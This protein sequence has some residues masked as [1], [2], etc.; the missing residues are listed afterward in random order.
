MD[1]LKNTYLETF[2]MQANRIKTIPSEFA[3]LISLKSVNF[4]EN[5]LS[6]FPKPFFELKLQSINLSKNYI[7]TLPESIRFLTAI[8]KL[9]LSQNRLSAI[10]HDIIA[11]NLMKTL[12]LHSNMLTMIPESIGE[13]ASLRT[14]DVRENPIFSLPFAMHKL[15][16]LKRLKVDEA[17]TFI[18]PPTDIVKLGTSRCIDYFKMRE[19][20]RHSQH[21]NMSLYAERGSTDFGFH[22]CVEKSQCCR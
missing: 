6:E 20:A 8:T 3:E 9:N 1:I 10:C 16:G 11:L 5:L 15:T 22:T 14:L 18:H 13:L 12:I 7:S 2:N 21:L 17:S 4:E 19:Q